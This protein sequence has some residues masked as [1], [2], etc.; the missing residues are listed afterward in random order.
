MENPFSNIKFGI[1]AALTTLMFALVIAATVITSSL[2]YS[3]LKNQFITAQNLLFKAVASQISSNL[4]A[5]KA[6]ASTALHILTQSDVRLSVTHK[7]RLHYI[8]HF[9]SILNNNPTLQAAYIG[10]QNGDF[11]LVRH[12]DSTVRSIFPEAPLGTVWIVQSLE[13]SEGNDRQ[14]IFF[15][16]G[17][18]DNY[19]GGTIKQKPYDPRVRPWYVAAQRSLN[20]IGTA[21]YRFSTTGLTGTTYALAAVDKK[22]VFGLDV[23]LSSA[24]QIL[25][26]NLPTVG[27]KMAILNN[28]KEILFSTDSSEAQ[29]HP[30]TLKNVQS[31][32]FNELARK[33]QGDAPG[34]VAYNGEVWHVSILEFMRDESGGMY[35]LLMTPESELF[36]EGQAIVRDSLWAPLFM[37]L[38]ILPVGWLFSRQISK[39]ITQLAKSLQNVKAMDFSPQVFK[40][41]Y[42]YEVDALIKSMESMKNTVR[43][44]IGLSKRIVSASECDDLLNM[45]LDVSLRTLGADSAGLWLVEEGR[46]KPNQARTME[47]DNL[48]IL[49]MEIDSPFLQECLEKH[50]LVFPLL[51]KMPHKGMQPLQVETSFT[52]FIIPLKMESGELLGVLALTKVNYERA[53][54][55]HVNYLNSLMGFATVAIEN[56]KLTATLHQFMNALVELIANAIDAKSPYT[57]GH[58][59]RVPEIAQMLAEALH[60]TNRPPFTGFKMDSADR[61]ALYLASWLHDCGKITTPES[62]ADKA[63]KLECVYN[64][65]HEIRMRFEL[66]KKDV[67][68]QEWKKKS[69]SSTE[70]EILQNIKCQHEVLDEEFYFIA[71]CNLGEESMREEDKKRIDHIAQRRWLRTLDDRV[72]LGH[73]EL[74]NYSGLLKPQLPTWESLLADKPE[75]KKSRSIARCVSLDNPWG[76]NMETPTFQYNNGEL[77]NLKISRGTLTDEDRYTINEHIIMTIKMLS[78]LPFPAYLKRVPEMAGGHHERMDGKGYPRGLKKEQMSVFARI[79]AIADVFEALTAGDRPYKQAKKLSEA[80]SI[81]NK[82]ADEGHLDAELFEF[83][84]HSSIWKEYAKKYLKPEQIDI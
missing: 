4:D 37:L 57:A 42:I 31:K 63:T 49:E 9:T 68:L 59:N 81:M 13:R 6:K 44:F 15:Y 70:G 66:I 78:S 74:A 76:F 20:L 2:F 55:S 33:W 47:G 5:E 29:P 50:K 83:F 82:M 24:S 39:P 54:L 16:A 41:T 18:P 21:P 58:C 40:S 72:G 48:D 73:V 64:R 23:R 46:L 26:N 11:F 53:N 17:K 79:M 1:Y 14:H 80:M 34:Q 60:Q 45:T 38:M 19:L 10:Y 61:E 69:N 32:I 65:V 67:E 12:M 56:K 30:I 36:K 62:I 35:L 75:H 3:S 52:L 28:N 25:K 51:N 84:Y 8:S 77:V 7:D 22:S 71:R 27:S 43:D